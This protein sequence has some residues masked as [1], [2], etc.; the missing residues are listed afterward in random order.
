MYE[1]DE[2]GWR[3]LSW[4]YFSLSIALTLIAVMMREVVIW[5]TV[6]FPW[7]LWLNAR[8]GFPFKGWSRRIF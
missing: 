5:I 8:S 4:V 3:L 1:L 7:F 2:R 6:P